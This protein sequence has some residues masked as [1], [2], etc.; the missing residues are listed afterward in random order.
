MSRKFFLF[1]EQTKNFRRL[2]GPDNIFLKIPEIIFSFKAAESV[3]LS[4]YCMWIF[5]CYKKLHMTK[6][7]LRVKLI[8]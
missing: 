5:L 1:L 2:L 8:P 4:N 3:S 6:L 7:S